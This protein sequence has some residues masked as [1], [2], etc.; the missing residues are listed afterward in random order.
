MKKLLTAP[1]SM[2]IITN[3][4]LIGL[5]LYGAPQRKEF[6]SLPCGGFWLCTS[7]IVYLQHDFFMC[8]STGRV[9]M[10]CSEVA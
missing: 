10:G 5:L 7:S 8:V 6:K 3:E 4:A 9:C 2:R 1:V